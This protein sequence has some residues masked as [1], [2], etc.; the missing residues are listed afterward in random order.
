MYRR[1]TQGT[2]LD[3]FLFSLMVDERYNPKD[4]LLVKFADDMTV[5]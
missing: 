2:V 4:N 1:E 3:P 5:N